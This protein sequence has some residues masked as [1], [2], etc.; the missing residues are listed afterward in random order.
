MAEDVTAVEARKLHELAGGA[1]VAGKAGA[2]TPAARALN[3]GRTTYEGG[4]VL[5]D[6]HEAR[7]MLILGLDAERFLDEEHLADLVE[8]VATWAPDVMRQKML[9]KAGAGQLRGKVLS[10]YEYEAYLAQWRASNAK[11]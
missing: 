9:R 6:A 2:I 10:P 7:R 11:R 1:P 4:A 8:D 5:A 3:E